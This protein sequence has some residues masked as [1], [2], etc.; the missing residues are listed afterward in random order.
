MVMISASDKS[1]IHVHPSVENG[2]YDLHTT[3]DKAG[4][5]R[6]WLQF[7]ADGEVHT[8]D[9]T[10]LVKEGNSADQAGKTGHQGH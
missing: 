6:G 7:K 3:F 9:F 1:Y 2:K 5:Y 8:A 4:I 10:L